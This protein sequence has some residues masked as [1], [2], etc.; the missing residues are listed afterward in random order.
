MELK[1]QVHKEKEKSHK[2]EPTIVHNT[3]EAPAEALD[4]ETGKSYK[5][6]AQEWR[7]KSI[8]LDKILKEVSKQLKCHREELD[9]IK[10]MELYV[11]LENYQKLVNE[12]NKLYDQYRTIKK[13]N[14]RVKVELGQS[15]QREQTFLR[16]LKKTKEFGDQ[17]DLLESDY[18]QLYSENAEDALL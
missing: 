4:P 8:Q 14:K 12:Y 16:L 13:A 2:R 1:S 18:K 9:A 15:N 11:T 7:N 10:K 5:E 6:S 17:A 3:G